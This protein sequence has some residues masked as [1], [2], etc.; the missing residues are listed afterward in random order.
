MVFDMGNPYF[1]AFLYFF[2]VFLGLR[3]AFFVLEKI[4]LKV[5]IKTKSDVDDLIMKK[6]SKPITYILLL[7]TLR[8]TLGRLALA[9][10]IS[11][12]LSNLIYSLIVIFI[13][14]LAYVLVDL[15][16]IRALKRV[17]AKTK[18]KLDDSIAVLVHSVLKISLFI[19]A[20]LYIL[21]I[22]G[23][24]ILPL[25]GALGVAGLAVALALQPVLANI[26]SGA[27][28]VMDKSVGVGDLIYL[29]NETKGKVVK[30]GLRS[31]KIVSF[32]NEYFIVP[33][34]KLAESVIQNVAL[35]EPKSRVV[36][37]FGVEYGSDV[38]KVKEIVMKE[39]RSL[40]NFVDD[41]TPDVSFREMGDSALLFKAYF[42][43]DDFGDRF[44]SK[45]EANTK[46][47]K[48][49]NKAGIGI[50]FPQMD[51]HLKK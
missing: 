42:Y 19:V 25:L 10:N 46:I 32:D 26:F 34:T 7:V 41:P 49:L 38:D 31:T 16:V 5:T 43:V 11:G 9:E 22:W 18:S 48:A 27:S 13:G 47:Y 39:I 50:P 28:V 2:V 6:S 44:S 12:V 14:Y 23:V 35:P 51:V 4:L 17:T 37:P 3:I 29:D 24:E 40:K 33:N 36:I 15:G 1:S 20:V 45:D 8:L 30:V 21:N